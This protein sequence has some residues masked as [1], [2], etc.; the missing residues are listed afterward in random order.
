M[1]TINAWGSS[2]PAGVVSGGTG[3]ASFTAFSIITAGTTATGPFQNVVGVGT[4]G[5]ILTSG[6]AGVLPS[7]ITG[8]ASSSASVIT[9][10]NA[11]NAT[12]YPVWVTANT[13]GLPLKVSSTKLSFNPS[14]AALSVPFANTIGL[15]PV[16]LL[17]TET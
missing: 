3:A 4:S 12:M 5:Q 13:G 8:A 10:D 16:I 15:L 17:V 2:Y 9:D 7:W 14:T 1:A 11:T 6:G